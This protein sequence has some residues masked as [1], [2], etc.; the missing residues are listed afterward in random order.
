MR[1]PTTRRPCGS[2]QGAA[3]P[4]HRSRRGASRP[5]CRVAR[6]RLR[7]PPAPTRNLSATSLGTKTVCG[8]TA[9]AL[10]A[11]S[12]PFWTGS[13][14]TFP[15]SSMNDQIRTLT[16]WSTACRIVDAFPWLVSAKP[17][18]RVAGKG[19]CKGT[20]VFQTM[21]ACQRQQ[22]AA[23]G[24]RACEAIDAHP[25]RMAPL[26]SSLT[27]TVHRKPGVRSSSE[28]TAACIAAAELRPRPPRAVLSLF[29]RRVI[30]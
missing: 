5:S 30:E 9:S 3:P 20:A 11:G 10:T 1:L 18:A 12:G 8:R 26:G 25:A 21:R 6:S 27:A 17:Q 7:G 29:P 19:Q 4:T 13:S 22:V 14:V 28:R 2:G 24:A 23:G 16:P 15:C